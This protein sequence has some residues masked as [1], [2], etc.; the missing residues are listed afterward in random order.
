MCL[1]KDIYTE[2]KR[3]F[4]NILTICNMQFKNR[5]KITSLRNIEEWQIAHKK[6]LNGK[7]KLKLQ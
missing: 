1:I 5:K 6:I 7:C 2:Y 4:Q 3:N